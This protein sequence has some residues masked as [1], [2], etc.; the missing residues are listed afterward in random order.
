MTFQ[1]LTRPPGVHGSV[2]AH[3]G[4]GD[5]AHPARRSRRPRDR[6][7]GDRE[8]DRAARRRHG[9]RRGHRDRARDARAGAAR[10]VDE[11]QHVEPPADRRR[12]CT[13]LV[14][15]ARYQR[16]RAG[17]RLP[18]VPAGP[19]RAGSPSR[20]TSSRPPRTCCRAQDLAGK[21]LVVTAGPTYE[22]IDPVRFVGNRSSRQDGRAIAAAAQRRGARRHA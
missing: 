7:A 19:G 20:P 5:R 3:R 10:A 17:R 4:G 22:A 9:R 12:T 15:V 16:R 14:D 2:L 1:A 11:R 6:R 18:R 8:R 13:R 21:R